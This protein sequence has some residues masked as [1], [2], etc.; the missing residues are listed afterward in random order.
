MDSL[1]SATDVTVFS[2]YDTQIEKLKQYFA[3]LDTN[4]SGTIAKNDAILIVRALGIPGLD[5]D[6]NSVISGMSANVSAL[7][8][9][10]VINIAISMKKS[11]TG[12]CF[13]LLS[14]IDEYESVIQVFKMFDK[15]QDGTVLAADLRQILSHLGEVIPEDEIDSLLRSLGFGD[16]I[17]Y[18]ELAKALLSSS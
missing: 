1:L 10:D 13:S 5:E 7:S 2:C 17:K 9:Q 16:V 4:N 14:Q 11:Q 15:N 3:V 12:F 8:M 18:E 6:Y